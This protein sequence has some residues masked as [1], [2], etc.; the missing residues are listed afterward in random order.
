M[1]VQEISQDIR[2]LG[3]EASDFRKEVHA[4]FGELR[5]SLMALLA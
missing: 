5:H 2:A 3:S 1:D 4:E